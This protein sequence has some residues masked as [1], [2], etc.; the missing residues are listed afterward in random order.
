MR[1]TAFRPAP[2]VWSAIVRLEPYRVKP[3]CAKEFLLFAGLVKAAFHCRRKMLSNSLKR[4]VSPAQWVL[5]G[6]DPSRRPQTLT[7][8]EFVHLSN[9]LVGFGGL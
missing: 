3:H 1:P 6:I 2:K 4:Q 7:V 9:V 8:G 5:A